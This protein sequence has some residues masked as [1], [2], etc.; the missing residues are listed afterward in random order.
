M[1]V[2]A[3]AGSVVAVSVP[4]TSGFDDRVEIVASGKN[5]EVRDLRGVSLAEVQAR[6][7]DGGVDDDP[8]VLIARDRSR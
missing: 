3:A 6:P 4:S 7:R 1:C 8:S 5:A 2:S